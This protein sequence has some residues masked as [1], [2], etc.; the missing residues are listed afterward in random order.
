MEIFKERKHLNYESLIEYVGNVFKNVSDKRQKGKVTYSMEDF[1]MSAFGCFY[2]QEPSFLQFQLKMKEEMGRHNAE[3]MLR[4]SKIASENQIRDVINTVNCKEIEVINKEFM[5]RLQ[6]SKELEKF[7]I[8][9]DYILV[10][11]DGVQY[12]SSDTIHC[13]HC[14]HKTDKNGNIHYSHVALQAIIMKPNTRQVLPIMSEDIKNEDG[15][16]KQDC[17]LNAAKRLLERLKQEYPKLNFIICGDDLYSKDT[18]IK[19]INEYGWKF[20]MT[21]K[22]TSHIKMYEYINANQNELMSFSKV[23]SKKI[24]TYTHSWMEDVPLNGNTNME[25]VNYLSLTITN[26]KEA[27]TYS[28]AWVTDLQINEEIIVKLISAARAR[29][30][31]ENECFN[32]LKNQGYNLEHNFGHGEKLAFNLYVLMLVAFFIHQILELTDKL[33]IAVLEKAS[34]RKLA[35][36]RIKFSVDMIFFDSWKSMLLYILNPEKFRLVSD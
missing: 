14:L 26:D 6:R 33:F 25:I 10:V 18:L 17:E 29:W 35:W 12:F 20:L 30:K 32:N 36:G 1:L 2:F 24:N 4:I 13:K 21:A 31:I 22:D 9:Q 27:V 28:C 23:D 5:H 11:F 34:Q 15:Y 19:Q 7:K 16:T 8:F 3:S